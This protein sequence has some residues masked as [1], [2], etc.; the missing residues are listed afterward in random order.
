MPQAGK[1]L[2]APEIA[3]IFLV[4]VDPAHFSR[5]IQMIAKNSLL[6]LPLALLACLATPVFGDRE[7]AA[8][9]CS[10][11]DTSPVTAGESSQTARGSFEAA[12]G[13]HRNSS[14]VAV[15]DP[16]TGKLRAATADEMKSLA[17]EQG[18]AWLD[19]LELPT[20][21]GPGGT[22]TLHLDE[23]FHKSSVATLGSDG[24]VEIQHDVIL[25]ELPEPADTEDSEAPESGQ[26]GEVTP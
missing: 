21:Y 16:E 25:L 15:I 10:V 2:P 11:Q 14:L 18:G 6:A 13:N 20:T 19:S 5:G 4:L 8:E 7:A 26:E 24:K 23:R 22:V 3:F 17:P 1:E 12:L 9:K